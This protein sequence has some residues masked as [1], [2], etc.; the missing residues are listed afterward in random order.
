MQLQLYLSDVDINNTQ[1]VTFREDDAVMY[2]Q[3]NSSSS[4]T[5]LE[6]EILKWAEIDNK[7]LPL[8]IR[9][10]SDG[11]VQINIPHFTSTA[12]LDPQFSLLF[13]SSRS[14]SSNHTK[15]I[16]GVVSGAIVLLAV[17]IIVVLVVFRKSI[18]LKPVFH[19]TR[20]RRGTIVTENA[21]VK[22]VNTV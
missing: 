5:Q 4:A 12:L 18:V 6:A 20:H 15:M 11:L 14:K 13:G 10:F 9:A 17:A 3:L 16:A 19:S 7:T 22:N 8:P 21:V 1:S 2:L